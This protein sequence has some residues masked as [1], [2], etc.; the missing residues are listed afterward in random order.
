MSSDESLGGRSPKLKVVRR[1]DS[2]AVLVAS[3]RTWCGQVGQRAEIPILKPAIPF[4]NRAD[5]ALAVT[6]EKARQLRTTFEKVAELVQPYAPHPPESHYGPYTRKWPWTR[7]WHLGT[8]E[9]H[10]LWATRAAWLSFTESASWTELLPRSLMPLLLQAC[11]LHD[12]G[13]AGDLQY[14][15][16]SKKN[17]EGLMSQLKHPSYVLPDQSHFD[18]KAF[19][20]STVGWSDDEV[21][22]LAYCIGCHGTYGYFV[23]P[24]VTTPEKVTL[25]NKEFHTHILSLG[26]SLRDIATS[27]GITPAVLTRLRDHHQAAD[28]AARAESNMAFLFRVAVFMSLCDS[29]GLGPVSLSPPDGRCRGEVGGGIPQRAALEE[30][31][32]GG[33][34]L[35][36]PPE[37]QDTVLPYEL[38]RSLF[39]ELDY[40]GNHAR[41]KDIILP[42][43]QEVDFISQL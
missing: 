30:V 8:L 21:A 20:C 29:L 34:V 43:M 33:Q 26:A 39:D 40:R 35:T 2:G 31:L 13:K 36:I 23:N 32:F 41:W 6:L 28:P 15:F 37:K 17:H 38:L 14:S 3:N 18:L 16:V 12:V 7:Q 24:F 9:Q 4:S 25:D 10:L 19:L 1:R 42:C 11:F 27:A 22:L 5:M